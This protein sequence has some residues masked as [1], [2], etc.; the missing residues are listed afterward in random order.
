MGEKK[1]LEGYIIM[2]EIDQISLTQDFHISRYSTETPWPDLFP[3]T[4]CDCTVGSN[5]TFTTLV[6]S[7]REF[8]TCRASLSQIKRPL[9]T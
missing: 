5:F 4:D 9:S 2:A 6:E 8:P 7:D 3:S 1:F